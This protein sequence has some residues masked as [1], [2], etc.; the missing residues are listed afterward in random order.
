MIYHAN[1][2]KK[3]G[4][5]GTPLLTVKAKFMLLGAACSFGLM[6]LFVK[7]ASETYTGG[8]IAFVRSALSVLLFLALFQ[9]RALPRRVVNLPLLWTRGALGGAAA[10]CY[11]IALEHTTVGKAAL[12]NN[13]S[14]I[15]A[16]LL[17]SI[18]LRERLAR[19]GWLALLTSF[20]GMT[21]ILRPDLSGI[22][23]GDAIG[24]LSGALSGSAYLS[25]RA[26]RKTDSTWAIFFA[27]SLGG[28]AC[29]L[30]FAF[31]SWPPFAFPSTW[32]L[33]G[34]WASSWI[35]QILMTYSLK[36]IPAAEGGILVLSTSVFAA[37][38]GFLIL[39]QPVTGS[40]LLGGGLILGGCAWILK[41]KEM[42]N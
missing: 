7:L 20:G 28:L 15:F 17:S 19:S 4:R 34:M 26:L 35:A 3:T 23:W 38:W 36:F 22:R 2:L 5:R 33:L 27:F 30:P 25:I 29:S 9:G 21:L 14:P 41:A 37:L 10:L 16:A 18:A 11:F 12:L 42:K 32:W 40:D 8:Q 13:T 24:L 31:T 39:G 1:P 6:A